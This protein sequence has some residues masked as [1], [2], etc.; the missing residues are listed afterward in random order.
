[1]KRTH[2]R[3][4]T[5][6]VQLYIKEDFGEWRI[7]NPSCSGNHRFQHPRFQHRSKVFYPSIRFDDH[8]L[9]TFAFS[10]IYTANYQISGVALKCSETTIVPHYHFCI[11]NMIL[12][13]LRNNCTKEITETERYYAA[14]MVIIPCV[15]QFSPCRVGQRPYS[16]RGYLLNKLECFAKQT[17]LICYIFLQYAIDVGLIILARTYVWR[18]PFLYFFFLG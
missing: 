13:D 15:S 5:Y 18:F 6:S 14:R 7:S 16:I 17:C 12:T 9:L 4:I 1:M 10:H 2:G 8:L 3:P 11:P